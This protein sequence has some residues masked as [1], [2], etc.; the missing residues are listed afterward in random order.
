MRANPGNRG[1]R[2]GRESR[3][4]KPRFLRRVRDAFQTYHE[5]TKPEKHNNPFYELRMKR[6]SP[7]FNQLRKLNFEKNRPSFRWVTSVK[8]MRVSGKNFPRKGKRKFRL[9][10]RCSSSLAFGRRTKAALIAILLWID[11]EAVAQTR[12]F[13]HRTL[14]VNQISELLGPHKSALF[15]S[16]SI[17]LMGK[18]CNVFLWVVKRKNVNSWV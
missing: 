3:K 8:H 16:S 5:H 14:W 18:E 6:R 17:S 1:Q 7:F 13:K 12:A 10:R 4:Q 2:Y 9:C 11:S 15:L